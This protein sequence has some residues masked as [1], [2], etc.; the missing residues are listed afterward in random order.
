MQGDQMK[1]LKWI[2]IL[3]L[4]FLAIAIGVIYFLF[5]PTLQR[6]R[7]EI[8]STLAQ[9]LGTE[10]TIG[11]ISAQILPSPRV[12][13]SALLIGGKNGIGLKRLFIDTS[14]SELLSGKLTISEISIE[15]PTVNVVKLEDGS[16]QIG[17][18][19]LGAKAP[20]APPTAA[21]NSQDIAPGQKQKLIDLNISK[22]KISDGQIVYSEV[23]KNFE[24]MIDDFNLATDNFSPDKSSPFKFSF[25]LFG[26][27]K[28]NVSGDGSL[29]AN[30]LKDPNPVGEV[31]LNLSSLDL[32][33]VGG[34]ASKFSPALKGLTAKGSLSLKLIVASS[35]TG[36][37]TNLEVDAT[38]AILNLVKKDGAVLA[39]KAESVPLKLSAKGRVSA[40][41]VVNLDAF[42]LIFA[43]SVV[44]GTA[45]IDL[46]DKV[47]PVKKLTLEPEKINLDDIGKFVTMPMAVD[48]TVSGGLILNLATKP[49]PEIDGALQIVDVNLDSIGVGQLNG[50][51]NF[52]KNLISS[53]AINLNYKGER[54]VVSGDFLK[55]I[56]NK[57]DSPAI[58]IS[59]LGGA[60]VVRNEFI[61]EGNKV[62]SGSISG[63]EIDLGRLL[64]LSAKQPPYAVAGRLSKVNAN[65]K[66]SLA[67]LK[68]DLA[69]TFSVGVL[70]GEIIGI[71]LIGGVFQKLGSLP[72]VR[73]SLLS[74]VPEK[75]RAL[76]SA[77]N[78]TAF[79]SLVVDGSLNNGTEITLSKADL[80]YSAFMI[81]GSGRASTQGSLDLKT[82]MKIT[83]AVTESMVANNNKLE[84][85]LDKDENLTFPLLI[86]KGD[87]PVVVLPDISEL[88]KNALRNSAKD[89]ASKALDKVAPGLGNGAS[90]LLNKLF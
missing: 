26:T 78:S 88:G 76:V 85:L 18:L 48:G 50:K 34:L 46:Q 38:K 1:W 53:D 49:I 63:G 28:S 59:A 80:I 8:V 86:S 42:K 89:A 73:D 15:G 24:V 39:N 79:D 25:T 84:L 19:K 81:L 83:K 11:G 7:P 40:Q 64:A 44:S 2:L 57:L 12:E 66:G 23:S 37:E 4:G 3:V 36:M 90:K 75:Y 45:G 31:T 6:L 72:G 56:G 82:Q 29:I 5:N 67:N 17:E 74:L 22:L 77:T 41:K 32:E 9:S 70:K 20:K 65:Y 16:L 55:H 62:F 33:Q 13:L 47:S 52:Q 58:K 30:S 35:H 54:I 61:N 43:N 68:Q 60:V 69:A 51:L 10:V 27:S 71:N 87:G 14:I 21:A